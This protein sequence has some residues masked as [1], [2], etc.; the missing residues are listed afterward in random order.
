MQG[1]MPLSVNLRIKVTL[2]NAHARESPQSWSRATMDVLSD[3]IATR[4][5]NGIRNKKCWMK[6]RWEL[7]KEDRV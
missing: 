6:Y 2:L 7:D 5:E 1:L 3:D 4:C